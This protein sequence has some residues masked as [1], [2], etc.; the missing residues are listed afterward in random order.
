ML[1]SSGEFV[2]VL[3]SNTLT[4]SLWQL[5]L[6][7]PRVPKALLL[8][9]FFLLSCT[10]W[11][12]VYLKGLLINQRG[13]QVCRKKTKRREPQLGGDCSVVSRAPR[14]VRSSKAKE[15]HSS[16]PS[17][18]PSRWH[19]LTSRCWTERSQHP[20]WSYSHSWRFWLWWAPT[21]DGQLLSCF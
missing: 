7:P 2:S 11:Y 9:P 5:P 4:F 14:S 20:W 10:L 12:N 1:N 16:P 19:P 6:L 21:H 13:K 8:C 3:V 18:F 15:G 17:C